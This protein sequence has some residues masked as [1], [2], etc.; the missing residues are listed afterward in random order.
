MKKIFIIFAC[1]MLGVMTSSCV[2]IEREQDTE[3]HG[4]MSACEPLN[5]THYLSWF[6]NYNGDKVETEIPYIVVS[7]NNLDYEVVEADVT[8]L[9]YN[10]VKVKRWSRDGVNQ[11]KFAIS[12]IEYIFNII[13]DSMTI[14]YSFMVEEHVCIYGIFPVWEPCFDILQYQVTDMGIEDVDN[15]SYHCFEI[16][17]LLKVTH[18]DKTFEVPKTVKVI[19]QV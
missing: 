5:D 9:Q 19:E 4:P 12:N 3:Y 2:Y 18:G 6:I 8:D 1:V 17:I 16:N 7:E 15:K 11:G 10:D 13:C 14:S